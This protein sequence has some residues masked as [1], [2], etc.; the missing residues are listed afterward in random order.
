MATLIPIREVRTGMLGHLVLE[1]GV[2]LGR[3]YD[4]GR[5]G[6]GMRWRAYAPDGQSFSARSQAKAVQRLRIHA[7]RPQIAGV[8]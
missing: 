7:A 1:Q 3:L 6:P 8:V 4:F 5:D 2:E